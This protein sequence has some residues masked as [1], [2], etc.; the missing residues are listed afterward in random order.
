[1]LSELLQA[2]RAQSGFVFDI[3]PGTGKVAI[4]AQSG[5]LPKSEYEISDLRYSPV[6][7]VI[8]DGV[9]ILENRALASGKK[10]SYL[11]RFLMFE[12]CIGL[13]IEGRDG[14][15]PR[16]ALFLFHQAPDRFSSSEFKKALLISERM[17]L[18]IERREMEARLEALRPFALEGLLRS[19]LLHEINNQL[20]DIELS[21]RNLR[22]DYE[23]LKQ[24]SSVVAD[25]TFLQGMGGSISGVT[26]ASLGLRKIA[27]SFLGLLKSGEETLLNV[28]DILEQ[29][30][31]VVE[32]D[33][34][35]E[36][37]IRVLPCGEPL[38]VIG[39][40]S[41]LER[42]FV[43]IMLNAVQQIKAFSGENG[44]LIV[45]PS[46]DPGNGAKPIKLRFVDTGPGIHRKDFERIFERGFS[47]RE[48][49]SGLGLFITKGLVEAMGG[50]VR[51]EDSIMFVGS[52]FLIELPMAAGKE[53]VDEPA[54]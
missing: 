40:A 28:G 13:R 37:Q 35:S 2:T 23:D 6:R 44:A 27:S 49:G 54:D 24:D 36:V 18:A 12:S 47:T 8:R 16:H 7:D 48:G 42:A 19:G 50:S 39:V 52:R 25:Q 21:A 33:A 15:T 1:M 53:V 5:R 20:N 4:T 30:K 10:F 17:A 14:G 3:E 32:P 26:E 9:P 41:R 46:R 38:Q 45:A 29:A 34:H 51:V 11:L 43:N 22:A 31:Q